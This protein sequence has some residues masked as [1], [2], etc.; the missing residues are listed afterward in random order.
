MVRRLRFARAGRRALIRYLLRWSGLGAMV[1]VLAGLSS[2]VF[3]EGLDRVTAARL[4]HGW[5]IW[6]LPAAGLAI[7]LSQRYLGGRACGG[8][9]LVLD[10]IQ[11]PTVDIPRRM[12]PL[13]LVG[14]W[15]THLF[16]G[17]AGREGTALQL[18]ASLTDLLGRAV[19]R[20]GQDRRRLA[21][22]AV[23]GGFG[24]MFGVPLAGAV[25]ALEVRALGAAR[26]RAVVPVLVAALV[27]HGVVQGLGHHH[28]LSPRLDASL[29]PL[30]LIKLA[31]A[32][33]AFALAAVLFVELTQAVRAAV[34]RCCRWSPLR[35]A[36]GGALVV[37][38]ATI[39]GR[40]YL[41]LSLPLIER[42]LGG[43]RLSVAVVALKL[44]FTAITLG[45]DFPGGEVTPLFVIG[46]TLGA[47][48]A[49][50]LQL[51]IT[52]VAA[53]GFVAVFAGAAHTPLAGAMMGVELFGRNAALPVG[54]VC[55]LTSQLARRLGRHGGIYPRSNG[56]GPLNPGGATG[57]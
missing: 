5:L 2:F 28:P 7:G 40:D 56:D 13:V 50:P 22:T 19:G 36:L 20:S 6:W 49:I 30:T 18:S 24:A 26:L 14:T 44:V 52:L 17:S 53:V 15:I 23:G 31:V 8:T 37:A 51:D 34:T 11:R 25:F 46:T 3:L 48:L 41:G 43:D 35:P 12:A 29:S 55:F 1:G 9:L 54:L 32:A 39:F 21:I 4:E 47:A 38:L 45:S 16:G 10:E 42:G 27:G 57:R 33:G